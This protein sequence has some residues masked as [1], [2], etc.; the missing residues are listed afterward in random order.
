MSEPER[1]RVVLLVE[2]ELFVRMTTLD[3]L[4]D[5]GYAVLEA[6]TGAEALSLLRSA[7]HIDLLV[8][9]VGLPDMDGVSLYDACAAQQPGLPA[10]FVT[11]YG[12]EDLQ[13]Q[14][15]AKPLATVLAKPYQ[16]REL[17]RVI[18]EA[19]ARGGHVSA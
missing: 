4:E 5:A 19:M 3:M 14:V 11:G 7:P 10:V 13:T 2:D 17:S 6:S 8:S 12:C 1:Q 16:Q 18:A 9:D 15:Q